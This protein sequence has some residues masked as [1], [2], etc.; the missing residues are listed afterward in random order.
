M[1]MLAFKAQVNQVEHLLSLASRQQFLGNKE[2]NLEQSLRSPFRLMKH[3][4]N[5]RFTYSLNRT[6]RY[7]SPSRTKHSEG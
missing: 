3:N 5:K 6:N 2:K 4:Y 7:A 1:V